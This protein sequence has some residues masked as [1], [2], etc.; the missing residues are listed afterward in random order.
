MKDIWL[1]PALVGI[2][3]PVAF[4]LE[5]ELG[6]LL[7]GAARGVDDT[8]AFA[9]S[10]AV[11]AACARAASSLEPSAAALPTPC[12]VDSA[13][14]PTTHAWHGVLRELFQGATNPSSCDL[15]LKYE[16]CALLALRKYA[17]PR[18][19]LPV[20]LAAG[21]RQVALRSVLLP[22]LGQRGR[23]LAAQNPEWAYAAGATPA[24]DAPEELRSWQEATHADRLAWFA[25]ARASDPAAARDLLQSS[26]GELPAKE[27][28]DFVLTLGAALGADDAPLLEPLLKDRSRDVRHVAARLLATL[29]HSAHAQ[30]LVAWIAPLL[31]ARRGLLRQEWK[32][33]APT[34]TDAAWGQ[35][36][37]DPVR[38]P[39]DSLGERAWWLYQLVRQ[40][41]LSW[42]TAHTEMSPS[43]LLRWA[44]K[45]D[46]HESLHRG[47]RE[48]VD[49]DEPQ[50]VAAM[51]DETSELP[52]DAAALLALLPASARE[53]YWPSN[54]D[55]LWKSG[56]A[57]D[58][59]A[60]FHPG[61]T[62]S[63]PFSRTLLPG[64]AACF[65]DDRLRHDYSLRTCLL[66]LASLLHP[67]CLPHAPPLVRP[68]DETPAMAECAQ[69]F[70][71]IVHLRAT[72]HA[73]SF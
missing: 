31:T 23:W 63:H 66:D 40:V 73:H 43:E 28:L 69:G 33:E 67:D 50:W 20:A 18:A 48:R 2:D 49:R 37:I 12:P 4:G 27:R 64:L 45:T 42:W 38:P 58:V 36:A 35:A 16:A 17:L 32:L 15:R 3:R 39:H 30:R 71:R 55:A 47:W 5:G 24:P 57:G 46:W 52:R 53:Q 41:P 54:M 44:A 22:V 34:Q 6:V 21:A 7:D 56:L 14:L 62:L 13:M 59:M 65:A 51:L 10:T 26:L 25:R 8:L 72:L 60:S 70:E 61:E 11:M 29:P 19:V 9:R 1:K 68:A